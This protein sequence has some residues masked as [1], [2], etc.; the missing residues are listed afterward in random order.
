MICLTYYIAVCCKNSLHGAR[1]NL[2]ARAQLSSTL[3]RARRVAQRNVQSLITRSFLVRFGRCFHS[4]VQHVFL[5]CWIYYIVFG[6]ENSL[7]GAPLNLRARAIFLSNLPIK[8]RRIF[9]N[10]DPSQ[11]LTLSPKTG[12]PPQNPPP[13]LA[14]LA[15]RPYA[16]LTL[17]NLR[18]TIARISSNLLKFSIALTMT[19]ARH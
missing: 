12:A 10:H 16:E 13:E 17:L 19:L 8:Y 11:T 4:L 1:L 7:D 3:L 9:P 2:R 6:C 5:I 18:A 15:R 14:A